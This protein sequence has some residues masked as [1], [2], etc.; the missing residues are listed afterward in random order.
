[1]G[2]GAPTGSPGFVGTG[3]AAGAGAL[4]R[5]APG[6]T[7]GG[8]RRFDRLEAC[9]ESTVLAD[10]VDQYPALR[11]PQDQGDQGGG[12]R[13]P[14]DLRRVA[15]PRQ[16]A[17][18]GITWALPHNESGDRRQGR[19]ASQRRPA[20][21]AGVE[22]TKAVAVRRAAAREVVADPDDE[23]QQQELAHQGRPTGPRP[24]GLSRWRSRARRSAA[25]PRGGQP[26]LWHTEVTHSLA[27]PR[28]VGE[29]GQSGDGEDGSQ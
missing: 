7:T 20:G 17:Q 12:E 10:E 23:E 28:E 9:Q 21:R 8:Q 22:L 4:R 1:M 2:A 18:T 3:A 11:N 25:A 29:L 27:G 26:S 15:Q 5:V 19:V 6:H 24:R 13:D 16:R 14:L